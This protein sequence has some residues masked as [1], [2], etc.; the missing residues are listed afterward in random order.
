MTTVRRI[1]PLLVG[2]L[3][4]GACSIR[5]AGSPVGDTTLVARF[6]DVQHLV[7][8]HTVR[9]ADV[10]VGTVTSVQLDGYDALVEMSISDSVEL[11]E[12]TTAGISATSLLGENFVRL[13]EPE[14][15]GGALLEDGD[16]LPTVGADASFEEITIE[17]LTLFRAIQGRD[18]ATV[19]DESHIALA[20]RGDELNALIATVADVSDGLVMQTDDLVA[21]LDSVA[22]FGEALADDADRLGE[23]IESAADATGALAEQRDRMVQTVAEIT[24]VARALDDEVLVPHTDRLN[25]IL[26]R[27][28]PTA[29]VLRESR[30]Q[31]VDLLDATLRA[32]DRIPRAIAPGG[33]A[34]GFGVI[35]GI[36]T[37][38]GT[39][40]PFSENAVAASAGANRSRSASETVGDILFGS[41]DRPSPEAGR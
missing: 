1:A 32:N 16:E 12:G 2:V 38:D 11:V 8:G 7:P 9:L 35:D 36:R 4:L 25:R 21:I 41:F 15:A 10:P 24:A 18:I 17:L 27:L 20:G 3:L 23:S 39:Y 31:L 19:I 33:S 6:D 28:A 34:I 13:K 37:T 26:E 40:I 14:G 5:T 30:G 29:A 22:E